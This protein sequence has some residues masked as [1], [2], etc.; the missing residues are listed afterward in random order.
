MLAKA[1]AQRAAR[2]QYIS[3]ANGLLIFGRF[4]NIYRNCYAKFRELTKRMISTFYQNQWI[5][6]GNEMWAEKTS[7]SP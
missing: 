2:I 3:C 6:N 1:A 4:Q 7:E 5:G